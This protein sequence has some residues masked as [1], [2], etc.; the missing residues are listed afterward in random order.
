MAKDN[1][2]IMPNQSK[3]QP[4]F[5]GCMWPDPSISHHLAFDMLFKYATE[6]CLVDCA[7][8]SSPEHLEAAIL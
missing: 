1:E 2:N 8:S 6:A 5:H 7:E 4:D 3:Y